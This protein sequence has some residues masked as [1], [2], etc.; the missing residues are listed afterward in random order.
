METAGTGRLEHVELNP[1][2]KERVSTFRLPLAAK[3]DRVVVDPYD[4]MLTER[5]ASSPVRTFSKT[6]AGFATYVDQAHQ[7]WAEGYSDV[8]LTA[9]PA[10]LNKCL[11]IGHPDTMPAIRPLLA[12]AGFEVGGDILSYKG[13]HIDL[14]EGCALAVVDLGGGRTCGILMG[15]T[16]RRPKTGLASVAICDELGQFLAGSTEPRKSG[17]WVFGF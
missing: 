17:H 3:P 7:N 8:K 16:K 15:K 14:T 5:G 4:V 12:A 2:G 11:L 1:T 6:V 10:E 13:I 9:P